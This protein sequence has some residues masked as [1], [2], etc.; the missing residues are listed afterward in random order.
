MPNE[1]DLVHA[2]IRIDPQDE[3]DA[4]QLDRLTRD[5]RGEMLDWGVE[6]A[7]LVRTGSAPGGSK[8]IEVAALVGELSAGFVM[9]AAVNV[10]EYLYEWVMRQRGLA[11]LRVNVGDQTFFLEYKPRGIS[12]DQLEQL[13]QALSKES[14]KTESKQA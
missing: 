14:G 11:R 8:T 1:S 9:G 7:D 12:P 2:T 3:M 10:L 6:S 13:V 4:E 5:L